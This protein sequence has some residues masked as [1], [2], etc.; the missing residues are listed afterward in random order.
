MLDF[1]ALMSAVALPTVVGF[2]FS[3]M[4]I[5]CLYHDRAPYPFRA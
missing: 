4:Q 2:L 5:G 1:V 3:R